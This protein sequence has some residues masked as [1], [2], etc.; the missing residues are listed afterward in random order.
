MPLHLIKLAVGCESVKD[1]KRRVAERALEATQSGLPRHHIHITRMVP[2]RGDELL[3][4]GSRYWGIRGGIAARRRL[5][6]IVPFRD[7]GA[8]RRCPLG[9]LPQEIVVSTPPRPRGL[10]DLLLLCSS[11]PR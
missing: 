8:V 6:A 4:G 7:R 1:L 3:A 2:K 11:A 10:R 9:A 5:H